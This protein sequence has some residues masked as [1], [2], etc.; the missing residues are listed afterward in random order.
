MAD[1]VTNQLPNI[2]A[3]KAGTLSQSAPGLVAALAGLSFLSFSQGRS[4]LS[5]NTSHNGVNWLG[6]SASTG[7]S[8][9]SGELLR[10][11]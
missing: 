11:S 1:A 7:F 8:T 9:N 4:T 2:L 6:L 5:E 10:A 3:F